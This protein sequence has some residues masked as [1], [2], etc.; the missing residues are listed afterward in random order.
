MSIYCCCFRIWMLFLLLLLLCCVV[1][2]A[3]LQ[4]Y[5]RKIILFI[6]LFTLF[7]ADWLRG[8]EKDVKSVRRMILRIE[9]NGNFINNKKYTRETEK[10]VKGQHTI[11]YKISIFR[12]CDCWIDLCRKFLDRLDWLRTWFKHHLHY[13]CSDSFCPYFKINI[14]LT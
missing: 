7:I 6:F 13:S 5:K 14:R 8:C 10:K 12:L 1:F 4:I 11:L 2:C 9:K 3:A